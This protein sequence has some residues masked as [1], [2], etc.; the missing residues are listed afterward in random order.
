[1]ALPLIPVIIGAVGTFFTGAYVGTVVEN[2]T[3]SPQVLI[4]QATVSDGKNKSLETK[5]FLI[6]GGLGVLAYFIYKKLWRR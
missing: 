2:A 1:M 3:D 4:Q 6:A 5:D